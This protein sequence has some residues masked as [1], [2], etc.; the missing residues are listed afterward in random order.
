MAAADLSSIVARVYIFLIVGLEDIPPEL[1]LNWDQTGI[2]LVPVSNH[3]IDRQGL[4]QLIT[5]IFCGSLTGDFLTMQITY[6]G[7][8]KRWHPKYDF[9]IDWSI[10]HSPNHWS[11]VQTMLEHVADIIVP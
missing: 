6:K 7:K 9:P 8:T 5:A 4:K 1:V 2:K 3:T 11:T 10:T